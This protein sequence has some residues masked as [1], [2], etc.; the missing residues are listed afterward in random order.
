MPVVAITKTAIDQHQSALG[1]DQR[2]RVRLHDPVTRGFHVELRQNGVTFYF[3]YFDARHRE[4]H[5]RIGRL[6]EVT[7]AQARKRAEQ[8]RA[9]VSL[10]GDPVAERRQHLAV[11]TVDRFLADR[12]LPYV[13]ANLRGAE[14]FPAYCRRIAK[15]LGRLSLNEVSVTDVADFRAAILK[16]GLAPATVNRHLAALRRM[17]TLASKWQIFGGPNPAASPGMLPE[18]NRDLYL[19]PVQV[20]ALLRALDRDVDQGAASAI[21]LLLFTGARSGEI[22]GARWA[23]VDLNRCLLTVPRSKAGRVHRIP[24]AQAAVQVLR[25]QHQRST[26]HE[27][28]F[29]G[30]VAGQ[31][32]STLRHIWARVKKA[33][34]LPAD[35]R[36]HDLRHTFASALVSNG[37]PL[38]EVGVILGHSQLSTTRRYAH[39]APQR[40]IETA[41]LATKSWNLLPTEVPQ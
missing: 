15:H 9:E 23:D 17:F 31:P 30:K 3:R 13:E 5:V 27:F 34:G 35:F 36:V 37:V 6:G 8:L 21:A 22:L 33:A 25:V 32:L 19:T 40:L 1:A 2:A 7:L 10:G 18:T 16:A 39:H 41:T 24:L 28:V 12:F 4:R 29:P 38:Y 11:P 20:Q 14:N 26:G